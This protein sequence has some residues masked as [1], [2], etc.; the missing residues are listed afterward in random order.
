MT[1]YLRPAI[2]SSWPKFAGEKKCCP[3]C[4]PFKDFGRSSNDVS[5]NTKVNHCYS[6]SVH[7]VFVAITN[8]QLSSC[9]HQFKKTSFKKLKKPTQMERKKNQNHFMITILILG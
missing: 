6:K 4:C 3:S 7:E 9:I 5:L 2:T 1:T 8:R